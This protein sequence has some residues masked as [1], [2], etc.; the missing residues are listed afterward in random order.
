MGRKSETFDEAVI[1]KY[2]NA[3][4]EDVAIQAQEHLDKAAK[5]AVEEFYL[6]YEP[7]YYNRKYNFY[8]NS[9][10]PFFDKGV[11]Q[12]TAGVILGSSPD[13]NMGENVYSIPAY[14]V[15]DMAFH[16]WHGHPK[17]NVYIAPT[18]LDR[19]IE[20][21]NDFLANQ[22]KYIKKAERRNKGLLK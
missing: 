14:Q 12:Y 21:K 6:V 18:P 1:L 7:K 10:M 20:A 17:A 13:S 22:D 19:I 3:V 2:L 4:A 9:Y 15:F 16:G 11:N 8:E 5:K